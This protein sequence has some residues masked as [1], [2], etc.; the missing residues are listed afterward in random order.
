M[1]CKPQKI[2]LES[3]SGRQRWHE[4]YGFKAPDLA[5]GHGKD[6]VDGQVASVSLV[7]F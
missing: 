1:I 5:S 2:K 3:V 4:G 7:V 6:G